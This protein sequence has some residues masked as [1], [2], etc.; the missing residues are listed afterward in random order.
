MRETG[1]TWTDNRSVTGLT[2]RDIHTC[3]WSRITCSSNMH[4]IGQWGQ[5]PERTPHTG[6]KLHAEE[7]GGQLGLNI[8]CSAVKLHHCPT[9]HSTVIC[10]CI[11]DVRER[12]LITQHDAECGTHG[13][14]AVNV[15]H[16]RSF[17]LIGGG[18]GELYGIHIS[19]V[20]KSF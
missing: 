3:I 2:H 11:N 18:G 19:K 4:A 13:K 12:P 16:G 1:C 10:L 15:L 6:D 9:L 7:H 5:H 14:N 8:V 20:C 17:R